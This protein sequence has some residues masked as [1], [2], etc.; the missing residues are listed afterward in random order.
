MQERDTRRVIVELDTWWEVAGAV[1]VVLHV[2]RATSGEI[3]T[4]K[5]T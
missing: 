1:G 2:F 4:M 3:A 5:A